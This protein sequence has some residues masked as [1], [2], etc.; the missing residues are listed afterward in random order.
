[1]RG[2][3]KAEL[4]N[5][6]DARQDRGEALKYRGEAEAASFLPRGEASALR[7]TSLLITAIP[8]TSVFC[9]DVICGAK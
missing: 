7:H 6:H 2:R 3:G 4:G 8:Q 9:K 5:N 1:M